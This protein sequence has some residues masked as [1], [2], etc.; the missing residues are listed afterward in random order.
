MVQVCVVFPHFFKRASYVSVGP[1]VGLSVRRLVVLSDFLNLPLSKRDATI[2]RPL[3]VYTCFLVIAKSN[4]GKYE[5]TELWP[6][7]PASIET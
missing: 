6:M 7:C 1:S 3:G 2:K 4:L 5:N